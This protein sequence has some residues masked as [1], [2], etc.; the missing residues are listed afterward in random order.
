MA[1]PDQ[2]PGAAKAAGEDKPLAL[3]FDC[4]PLEPLY[5]VRWKEP[6]VKLI[7]KKPPPA[8]DKKQKPKKTW[9]EIR[10]VNDAG[11]PIPDEQYVL[12]M[13]DKSTKKG[14]LDKRGR[15]RLEGIEP[16][17]Y[18]VS[19]PDVGYTIPVSSD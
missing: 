17:D 12:H 6:T 14:K 2:S 4:W 3:D 19:F 5:P 1:T 11:D 7:V 13:P 8:D 18:L 16:G 9:I 10:L 15:A